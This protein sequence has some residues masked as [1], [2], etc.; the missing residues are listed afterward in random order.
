MHLYRSGGIA[1]GVTWRKRAPFLSYAPRGFRSPALFRAGY[2][3]I[4]ALREGKRQI[5]GVTQPD[6]SCIIYRA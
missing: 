1:L 4:D 3:A 5:R 6:D 2:S